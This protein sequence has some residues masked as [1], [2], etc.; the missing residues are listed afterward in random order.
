VI[1]VLLWVVVVEVDIHS[2]SQSR[3]LFADRI[4]TKKVLHVVLFV[5]NQRSTTYNVN[6]HHL[7]KHFNPDILKSFLF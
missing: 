6:M 7:L 5:L 2:L 1:A 3:I 4:Q